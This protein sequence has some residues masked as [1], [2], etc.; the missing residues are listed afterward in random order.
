M[1]QYMLSMHGVA[2]YH[3]ISNALHMYNE[4]FPVYVSLLLSVKRQWFVPDKNMRIE[5]NILSIASVN[6][7]LKPYHHTCLDLIQVGHVFSSRNRA[8]KKIAYSCKVEL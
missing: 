3:L 8:E 5:A 7:L 6:V 4:I 2:P 1:K